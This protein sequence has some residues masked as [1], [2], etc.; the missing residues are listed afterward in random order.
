MYLLCFTIISTSRGDRASLITNRFD[1]RALMSSRPVIQEWVESSSRMYVCR[2]V[3]VLRHVITLRCK[4]E[5]R[6]TR[7]PR[8]MYIHTMIALQPCVPPSI[9]QLISELFKA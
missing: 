6:D 3:V 1:R 4:P 5:H 7:V 2:A 9:F 8:V